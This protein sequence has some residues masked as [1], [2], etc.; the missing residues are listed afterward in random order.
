[1]ITNLKRKQI[2][3][4][5]ECARA[6]KRPAFTTKIS[7]SEYIRMAVKKYITKQMGSI[8]E[9][10]PFQKIIWLCDKPH[11]P[12]DTSVHH[13]CINNGI[14]HKVINFIKN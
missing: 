3:L 13:D 1:M 8:V 2:Y 7:E 9:E 10:D 6:L 14:H 11:G 12:N 5:E 4:Y